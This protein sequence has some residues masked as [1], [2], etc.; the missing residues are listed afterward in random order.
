MTDGTH[1]YLY[2][3]LNRKSTVGGERRGVTG[4][5]VRV[6][7]TVSMYVREDIKHTDT[8]KPSIVNTDVI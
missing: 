2:R 5:K 8:D 7:I 6:R 1:L 3:S 4:G